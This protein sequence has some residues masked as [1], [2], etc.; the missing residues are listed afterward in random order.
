MAENLLRSVMAASFRSVEIADGSERNEGADGGAWGD[1]P[2][3][4]GC[5]CRFR[6]LA[7][8]NSDERAGMVPGLTKGERA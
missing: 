5:G 3:F 2:I 6:R 7:F 8:V 1:H 4:R